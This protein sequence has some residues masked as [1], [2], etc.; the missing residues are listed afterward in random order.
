MPTAFIS[1]SSEDRS[2]IESEIL[3]RLK[4]HKIDV[5]YSPQAIQTAEHWERGI[6][7]GL[8]NSDVFVVM[9]SPSAAL[10]PWVQAEVHWAFSERPSCVVPVMLRSCDPK[11][12]HL[13]L[14]PLQYVDFVSDDADKATEEMAVAISRARSAEPAGDTGTRTMSENDRRLAEQATPLLKLALACLAKQDYGQAIAYATSALQ[15][16]QHAGAYYAR[17][18]AYFGARDWNRAI[19]DFSTAIERR[20][21][22]ALKPLVYAKSAR[23]R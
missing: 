19:E 2:F 10:S 21:M 1:H 12:C 3:P 22:P 17:G 13:L 20:P 11:A 6:K 7:T 4:A 16:S 9:M 5:W 15:I 18:L 8:Q 23:A 14:G